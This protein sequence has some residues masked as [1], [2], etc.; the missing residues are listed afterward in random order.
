M[1]NFKLL[2]ASAGTG[3]RLKSHTTHRNKGLITLGEKP[4]VA[5]I[6]EKFEINVPIV[7]AVGH[8]KESLVEVITEMFPER[9]IEFVTVDNFDGPG[10]GLGY[11]LLCCESLLQCPFIFIPNDTI[12]PEQKIDYDP[13]EMG[14]WAGIFSNAS[15]EIDSSHYRCVEVVDKELI[16]IL[17][18]GLVTENIYVGLCGI[19]DYEQFW[20]KMKSSD[21][22]IEEGESFGLNGLKDKRALFITEWHD[23]GNLHRLNSARQAFESKSHNILPKHEEA[24]WIVNGKCIKYHNDS[25]FINDRIHRLNYLPQGAVPKLL[26]VGHNYFSYEY[27]EGTLLSKNPSRHVFLSFLDKMHELLWK[28]NCEHFCDGV[29]IQR[30]FYQEKSLERVRLYLERF[31]QE[32]KD[33]IINGR[34]V[35]SVCQLLEHLPWDCFFSGAIWAPF[36]GDLHGENV[37]VC[38]D[39]DFKL[40]DWRQNFGEENYE[41]GDIYYDFGKIL[42]G[43]IVRHANVVAENFSIVYKSLDSVEIDIENSLAFFDLIQ[44]FKNWIN[45]KNYNWSRV[46][47]IAALIFI[48]IAGLHHYPY[49]KFLFLLGQLKLSEAL[50]G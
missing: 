48:N 12:I 19:L 16:G 1:S 32:D 47:T 3:S 4:A 9:S 40:L 15:N 11:S 33:L 44:T 28:N 10:S 20:E 42:H 38:G 8:L 21:L 36:H 26:N 6:I 18:K 5:H 45:E 43:L 30:N 41:Y 22:A 50:D 25:K 13:S 34:Q 46:D 7:I 37:I 24:I 27:A 17:P 49:S 35:R 29:R 14:N 2:I 39:N 31:D 23:I